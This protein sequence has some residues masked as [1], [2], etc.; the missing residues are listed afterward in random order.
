[1][2][3]IKL[4]LTDTLSGWYDW[5]GVSLL[6]TK[7]YDFFC[8][9]AQ[10]RPRTARA[11]ERFSSHNAGAHGGRCYATNISLAEKITPTPEGNYTFT[12]TLIQRVTPQ[13]TAGNSA[14]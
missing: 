11:F 1:M 13:Q 2:K 12:N 9:E 4:N 10:V 8:G 7:G 5:Y 14:S 6:K 3:R